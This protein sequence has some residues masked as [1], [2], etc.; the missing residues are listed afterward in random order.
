MRRCRSSFA[1]NTNGLG[2]EFFLEAQF[3]PPFQILND[4][5]ECDI[6]YKGR[7]GRRRGG[8][9]CEG[10]GSVKDFLSLSL[11]LSLSLCHT[12]S[13]CECVCV[14]AYTNSRTSEALAGHFELQIKKF[15]YG[16]VCG[17]DIVLEEFVVLLCA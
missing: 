1:L 11:S 2:P 10:E 6:H 4:E 13:L 15:G 5:I 17:I 3:P 12:H 9:G 7:G 16:M 8:G 14:D